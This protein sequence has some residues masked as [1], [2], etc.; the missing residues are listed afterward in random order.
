MLHKIDGSIDQL[1]EKHSVRYLGFVAVFMTLLFVFMLYRTAT[2][3]GAWL[4]INPVVAALCAFSA[5]VTTIA[6]RRKLSGGGK[7]TRLA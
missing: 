2:A 3:S 7:D 5:V 4:V 6:F 1:A